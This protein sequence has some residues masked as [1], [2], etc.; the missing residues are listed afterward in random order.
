MILE[1]C[2]QNTDYK[3]QTV[4][5]TAKQ[6]NHSDKAEREFL[7]PRKTVKMRPLNNI[8]QFVSPNLTTDDN[9]K[10]SDGQ[11]I[12]NETDSHPLKLIISKTRAPTTVILGDSIRKNVY[13]NAITK[14]IKHKKHIVIKHFSGAKIEDIKH[15][16]KPTQEKQPA[17]ITIDVGTNDLP[18][19]KNLDEIAKEIVEF[20]NSIKTSEN[21]VVISSIVSRKDQFNNKAK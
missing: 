8:P 5:E 21:N 17:Q 11:L 9:D 6:N 13:G 1:N 10:E 20:A 7:T 2:R 4:K 16:V 3:P 14:S 12:Q 15:Y 18:G 19:N